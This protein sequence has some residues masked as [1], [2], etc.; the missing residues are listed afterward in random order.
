MAPS[1]RRGRGSQGRWRGRRFSRRRNPAGTAR[2]ARCAG[3]RLGPKRVGERQEGAA[4]RTMRSRGVED[5]R[6]ARLQQVHVDE[7]SVGVD[8]HEYAQI[9]FQALLPGFDGVVQIADALDLVPPRL[10]IGGFRDGSSRHALRRR[11]RRP[12]ASSGSRSTG[13]PRDWR[14]PWPGEERHRVELF[15][16]DAVGAS[17]WAC[18]R[19]IRVEPRRRRRL[20]GPASGWGWSASACACRRAGHR[21]RW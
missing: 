14:C 3:R 10:Q 13:A 19:S 17:A 6:P 11:T 9:A 16:G 20:A 12:R 18:G 1:W 21:G 2:C 15:G 4:S 5:A 8:L 7:A